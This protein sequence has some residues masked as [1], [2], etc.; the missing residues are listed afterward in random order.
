MN[1]LKL[2]LPYF[3]VFHLKAAPVPLTTLVEEL[4]QNS[5]DL[6]AA[7]YRYDAASKRP[8]QVG[9]LPDPR[10]SAA[11]LGVGHPFSTLNRSDFAYTAIGVTQ[12][13]PYPGKLALA[14]EQARKEAESEKQNYLQQKLESIARLKLAYYDWYAA[15]KGIEITRRNKDLLE[16]FEAIVRSRYAVGKA[17]QQEVLKAQVELSA[18]DQ[19]A[20]TLDQRRRSLE[21]QMNFLLGRARPGPM[22]EPP[23][24]KPSALDLDI[25]KVVASITENVPRLRA[26]AFMIDSRAVGVDRG[27]KDYKPDFSVSFQ[28]QHTGSRFP[29]YY[30]AS[31]EMKLP[32]HARKQAAEL[33]E[34]VA[35]LHEAR[36]SYSAIQ[37]D[38]QFQARDQYLLAK[39]SE[40]ALDRLSSGIIPQ[41]SLAL[42]SAT[43]GYEV[44]NVT[45]LSLLDSI[46]NVLT[47]ERQYY[48]EL[49]RHEQAIAR[50]EPIVGRELTGR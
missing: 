32:V 27:R 29:D 47:Y 10:I 50:L 21:A 39:T 34:A 48:D 41:A 1:L 49:A 25:E 30:M 45:F 12:E 28:W 35:K 37:Q 17:T 6:R 11:S 19:Q 14:S 16:R 46:M 2:A 23:D 3:L 8:S 22:G 43:A 4:I 31:A 9:A 36:Q 7:E 44:G 42:E 5:P 33:E 40:R 24:I 26:Q 20:D 13:V 15:S 38:L 18:L